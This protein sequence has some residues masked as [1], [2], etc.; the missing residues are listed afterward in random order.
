MRL[1][2][3]ISRIAARGAADQ[4]SVSQKGR[5]RSNRKLNMRPEYPAPIGEQTACDFAAILLHTV[6]QSTHPMGFPSMLFGGPVASA[7]SVSA[8]R[9]AQGCYTS[10]WQAS[11]CRPA[12][13]VAGRPTVSWRGTASP[14]YGGHILC[15]GCGN[16]RRGLGSLSRSSVVSR[17]CSQK[18][19]ASKWSRN[20]TP[21]CWPSRSP[22][23]RRTAFYPLG[24]RRRRTDAAR[25]DTRQS[26]LG[27]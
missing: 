13:V 27:D 19:G 4:S 1:D 18:D 22:I 17:H 25:I 14:R 12:D 21:R 16:P 15:V 26:H 3:P 20:P 2:I 7:S 10:R 5:R 11:R 23:S 8:H 6:S 9:V 24:G